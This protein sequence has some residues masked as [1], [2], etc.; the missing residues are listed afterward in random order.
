MYI[1]FILTTS[2]VGAKQ[3]SVIQK[4]YAGYR[5]PEKKIAAWVVIAKELEATGAYVH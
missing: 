2:G 4:N 3:R 5:L 1:I